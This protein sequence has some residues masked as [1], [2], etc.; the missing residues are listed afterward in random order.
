[1][2]AAD[3]RRKVVNAV[4][5]KYIFPLVWSCR[6]QTESYSFADNDL[7]GKR[8]AEEQQTRG[9]SQDTNLKLHSFYCMIFFF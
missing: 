4:L 5:D 1:M 3:V 2:L 9:V 6:D 8:Y 7:R